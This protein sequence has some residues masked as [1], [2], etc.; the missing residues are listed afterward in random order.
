MTI[1]K[2]GLL[3]VPRTVPVSCD[4]LPYTAHVRPLAY[5]QVK[6]IHAAT[7]YQKLLLLQLIVRSCKN[8]FCVFPRGILWHAFC[9][10]I[11]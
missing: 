11:L 4:V 7:W 8:V 6:C 1:K 10:W 2:C 9:V 5:N 3:A